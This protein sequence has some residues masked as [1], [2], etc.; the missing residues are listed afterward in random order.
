ML[1]TAPPAGLLR[2]TLH[3]SAGTVDLA[4]SAAPVTLTAT[5]DVGSVTLRVPGSLSYNVT[6]DV[7][8]GSTRVGVTRSPA[9][10]HAITAGT[11]T[12]SV[13]VEPGD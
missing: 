9:S 4:F 2:A 6:T 11:R 5:C 8:V 3:S 7:D 1:T 12:G 10:P 13:T